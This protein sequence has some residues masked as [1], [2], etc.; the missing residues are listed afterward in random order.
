MYNAG[1]FLY[2]QYAEYPKPSK[3]INDKNVALFV[4]EKQQEVLIARTLLV[5]QRECAR[6]YIF[7][8]FPG[9]G[10]AQ[11]SIHRLV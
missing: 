3:T 1:N 2:S 9:V 6:H 11:A 7:Q 8:A 4:L 5:R 10:V